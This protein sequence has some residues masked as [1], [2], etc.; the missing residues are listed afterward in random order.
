MNGYYVGGGLESM[1]TDNMSFKLEYRFADLGSIETS[2]D[3]STGFDAAD[4]GEDDATGDAE[5]G[6][7][8]KANPLVHS[9]R[10]TINWRF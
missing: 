8:A 5:A 9:V 7:S 1:F 10:A 2:Q 3:Y 6:V 4:D